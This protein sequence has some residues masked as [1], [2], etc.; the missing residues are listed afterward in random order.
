[1][2][3]LTRRLARCLL[4]WEGPLAGLQKSQLEDSGYAWQYR[5]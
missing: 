4:L 1:M 2:V 5:G 3:V